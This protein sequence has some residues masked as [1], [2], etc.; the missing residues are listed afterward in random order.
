M[1]LNASIHTCIVVFGFH[2][3]PCIDTSNI[4]MRDFNPNR[5]VH[6]HM[7]LYVEIMHT[8]MACIHTCMKFNHTNMKCNHK[9]MNVTNTCMNDFHTYMN[10]MYHTHV[11]VFHTY[12]KL[13]HTCMNCVNLSRPIFMH[14]WCI[15]LHIWMCL[16][17]WISCMYEIHSYLHFEHWICIRLPN[18]VSNCYMRGTHPCVYVYSEIGRASCRE[19]V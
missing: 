14:A 10:W 18:R 17:C 9:H 6:A 3:H 12:M 19:R 11:N 2:T 1:Y 4:D 8:Y 16:R 7:G 13:F 5:V 15:I